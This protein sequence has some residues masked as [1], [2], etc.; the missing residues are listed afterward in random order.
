M[1]RT[2]VTSGK[3]RI[4]FFKRKVFFHLL[5]DLLIILLRVGP[6]QYVRS[7]DCFILVYSISDYRSFE[8]M[9]SMYTWISRIRDQEMPVVRKNL[10]IN[11]ET[12]T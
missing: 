11:V 6:P 5:S 3:T 9:K 4:K 1:H 8:E 10:S 12:V 2:L 7:G